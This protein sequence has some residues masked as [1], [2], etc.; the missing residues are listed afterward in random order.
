VTTEKAGCYPAALAAVLPEAEHVTGKLAQQRNERDHQLQPMR[1][2]KTTPTAQVV[3]AGHGFVRNPGAGFYRLRTKA[4][5]P[6]G[7]PPL[8]MWA[9]DELTDLLLAG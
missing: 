8:A 9:R 2:F 5:C 3:C 6:G 4:M 1:G 7:P